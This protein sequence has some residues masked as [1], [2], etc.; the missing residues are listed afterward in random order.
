MK[1][2]KTVKNAYV[3]YIAVKAWK[4]HDAAV[5]FFLRFVCFLF[6]YKTKNANM[7]RLKV[8]GAKMVHHIRYEVPM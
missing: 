5:F 1:D 8:L 2:Q 6:F 3:K 4:K 7:L